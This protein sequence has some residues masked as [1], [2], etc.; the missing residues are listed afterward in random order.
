MGQGYT[1][2]DTTNN[3]ANGNVISAADLDGE[4]DAIVASFNETTGHTH[5]GTAAEG[6]AVSVIG[7]VQEYLADGTAFY[8]KTTAVYTLGKASNVWANL[9]LVTLT[10]SGTATMATVDINGGAIDGTIIGGTTRAAGSFT[11]VTAGSSVF[12]GTNV[13]QLYEDSNRVLLNTTDGVTSKFMILGDQNGTLGSLSGNLTLQAG[14]AGKALLGSSNDFTLYDTAGTTGKLIWDASAETLTVPNLTATSAKFADGTLALPSIAFTADPDTGFY[15]V[16]NGRF[17]AVNNGVSTVVFGTGSTTV[18]NLTATTADINGGAIDGTIIGGTTPAAGTFATAYADLYR[19]PIGS[20]TTPIYS[21]AADTDTGMYRVAPNTIAFAAGG[22]ATAQIDTNGFNGVIGGTTPASGAFTSVRANDG[23]LTFPSISFTGDNDLGFY[24]P[25]ANRM[26]IVTGGVSRGFFSS[27]GLDNCAI[28]VLAPAAGTFT[29]ASATTSARGPVGSATVPTFSFTADTA[30]GVYRSGSDTLGFA[31]AGVLQATV[32]SGGI[33]GVV[34]SAG[35]PTFSFVADPLT[36]MYR[37]GSD[38]IGF[39]T[40][41]VLRTVIDSTGVGIGTASPSN[42]LDINKTL[43][44]SG[45]VA[46]VRNSDATSATSY[47]QLK[48]ETG[49]NNAS[50]SAYSGTGGA[51]YL[52][53]GNEGAESMRIDASGH[54]IIPAGITLGTAA[55]VYSAANTLTDY[56]EGTWTPV[57]TDLTNNATLAIAI[58]TYTKVGNKVHVQGR[59]QLSSLGSVTGTVYLSGLPFN[60]KAISNNFG[61]LTVGRATGISITAGS[62]VVGDLRV[63]LNYVI[64]SLW[65]ATTGN[66]NLQ[67]T[68]LTNIGDLSF[69]MDYLSN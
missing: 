23:S 33:R 22:T 40:A 28:G 5:D 8:P 10:L 25:A 69:S 41:G 15:R 43:V 7:P 21:F 31:G 19:S 44:S 9:H 16:T 2:N 61:A 26:D 24:R 38:T 39:S 27:N 32:S 49:L 62:V 58:A 53:L 50:I 35:S 56:E 45:V 11:N 64:L 36:G 60:S 42:P 37:S 67:A 46:R 51:G 54:T 63:N 14:P 66:T 52:V 34:G 55:G 48:L 47:A 12:F 29:T 59:I 30:T 4:F 57:I 68:E 18:A 3:I 65:D 6:G 20:N 13:Q 1:R 17:D